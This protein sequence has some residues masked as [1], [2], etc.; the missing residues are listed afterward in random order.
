MASIDK[1]NSKERFSDRVDNYKKYRPGY[2][3]SLIEFLAARV[4]LS[5]DSA[6]ADIGSGTGILTELLL[7]EG[8]TVYAIEPNAKM[9]EAA[10]TQLGAYAN[11]SSI[12]G[13]GE[14]TGLPDQSVQLI[15]VAQAFHWIDPVLA[16]KEF[17]RILLPGGHIALLWN[18]RT[19]ES[20]FDKGYEQIKATYGTDYHEIRK[21]H[22]PELTEFF[23][24]AVMEVHY[25]R[26]SQQLDFEGLKGQVL[27]SSYMPQP[28]QKNYEEMMQ[29]LTTLFEENQEN[30]EVTITYDAKLYI[31]K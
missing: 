8:W 29:A 20:P 11:F 6:V 14:T 31:N 19:L 1:F 4:G 10:E 21:A 25:F 5:G 13:S 22:E 30:G 15:T 24:P 12:N 18:L 2:P 16:R 26:H 3:D 7:K 27:S 9:R 17:D 28:G 23:A